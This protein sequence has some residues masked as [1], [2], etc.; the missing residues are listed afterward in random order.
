MNTFEENMLFQFASRDKSRPKLNSVH[1]DDIGL[2]V[3]TDGY[4]LFAT[5][6]FYNPEISGKTYDLYELEKNDVYKEI[7]EKYI[8]WKK[9]FSGMDSGNYK[10]NFLLEIPE[11]FAHFSGK[12]KKVEFTINF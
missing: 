9:L 1:F 12:E 6:N 11:W 8:D 7:T 5:K 2:T 4:R 3:A 10:N